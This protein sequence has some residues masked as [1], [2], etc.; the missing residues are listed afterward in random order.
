MEL[1]KYSMTI[2]FYVEAEGRTKAWDI[3]REIVQKHLR[4]LAD[5]ISAHEL[6]DSE[7]EESKAVNEPIKATR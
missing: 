3:T 2:Q 6:S 1:K 7:A 4:N 5:V